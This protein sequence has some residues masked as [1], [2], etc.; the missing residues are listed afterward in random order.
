MN[1]TAQALMAIR[2]LQSLPNWDRV[3]CVYGDIEGYLDDL[4]DDLE[5]N[6][7]SDLVVDDE[8]LA[9]YKADHAWID[10]V[11]TEASRAASQAA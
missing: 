8:R 3:A 1:H 9:D 7:W 5:R 6:D 10:R 11:L 4:A 2:L